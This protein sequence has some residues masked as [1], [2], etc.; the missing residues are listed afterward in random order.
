MIRHKAAQHR[1]EREPK[2]EGVEVQPECIGGIMRE[3]QVEG[4]RWIVSRLGDAGVNAILADEMVRLLCMC[5]GACLGT[6][7]APGKCL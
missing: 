1:P 5:S 2:R 3:Y 4:L 7:L 6:T